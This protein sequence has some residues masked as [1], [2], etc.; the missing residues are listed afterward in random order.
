MMNQTGGRS[1]PQEG[2]KVDTQ[3]D[4][5]VWCK[6]FRV[7][8]LGKTQAEM[9]SDLGIHA[10]TVGRWE[11]GSARPHPLVLKELARLARQYD[12]PQPPE[13]DR[14]RRLGPRM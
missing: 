5:P 6:S 12:H 1:P 13:A 10:V 14:D 7:H 4:F 3:V 11:A 2:S 8:T 9:A